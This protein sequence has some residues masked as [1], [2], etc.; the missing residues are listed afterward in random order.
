MND[1][2]LTQFFES[3]FNEANFMGVW[4]FMKHYID[5]GKSTDYGKWVMKSKSF[6]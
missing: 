5:V 6:S 2:Q 3:I 1:D 4:T